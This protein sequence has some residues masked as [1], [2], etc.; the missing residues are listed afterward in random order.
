MALIKTLR[1][2]SAIGFDGKIIVQDKAMSQHLGSILLC[3]GTLVGCSFNGERGKKSLLNILMQ[4]FS[5]NP[6]LDYVVEPEVIGLE[7]IQFEIEL[8]DLEEEFRNILEQT[9]KNKKLK[10]PGNKRVIVNSDFIC[11]GANI[12][13]K[14]FDVLCLISDFGKIQDIYE[15]SFLYEFEVTNALVSLRKKGALK[16]L[17]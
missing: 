13:P 4:E 11:R 5:S 8:N 16:V 2:Q 1:E 3:A 14:E 10:P 9:E 15:N 6:S 17:S 12:E 7:L